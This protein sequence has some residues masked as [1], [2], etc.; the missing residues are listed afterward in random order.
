M[1][2]TVDIPF[3]TVYSSSP[4]PLYY[5]LCT[6]LPLCLISPVSVCFLFVKCVFSPLPSASLFYRVRSLSLSLCF[7]LLSSA[8]SLPSLF[9]QVCSLPPSLCFSLLSGV[10]SI[11]FSL[12]VSVF[13]LSLLSSIKCVLSPLLSASL[14][15]RVRSLSLL[16]SIKC[17]LSP[18]L[19]AFLFYRVCSLSPFSL[20]LS[21]I[22]CVLYPFSLLLS[23]IKCV[24]SFFLPLPFLQ[25]APSF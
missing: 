9:Y 24:L 2:L 14:F 19:S 15:C 18:F 7:S 11:P 13:S 3:T 8:F 21:S 20:F 16:S 10:F 25:W 12:P 22:K 23:S 17:V 1:W 6:P 5:I 4:L